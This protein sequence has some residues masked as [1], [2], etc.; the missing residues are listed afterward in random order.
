MMLFYQVMRKWFQENNIISIKIY[1]VI[2]LKIKDIPNSERP[3]ERLIEYGSTS[4]SN[5]EL[6]SI[7]LRCGTKDKSVKEFIEI[8]SKLIKEKTIY[9]NIV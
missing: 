4:L 2:K 3:R 5:E 1:Q 8:M 7:I 9:N 6:L